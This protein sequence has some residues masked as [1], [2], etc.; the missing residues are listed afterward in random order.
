MGLYKYI[1][2]AWK[3]PKST[4]KEF[5]KQRLIGWRREPSILRIEKPTRLDRA[6]S[7]GYKAKQG[8]VLTRTKVLKGGR[9]RPLIKKGRRSKHRRRKKILSKSYQ[10]I[11]EERTAK[12]FPNLEV[13]GSYK[14]AK[15]GKYYFY[16]IILVDP[17]H[18]QIKADKN[19]NWITEPQHRRRVFRGKT[20]SA[21]KSRGLRKKGKGAEKLRPSLRS[22][23][24][25]GTN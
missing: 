3:K 8:F 17:K 1:R 13:L 7:L 21:R 16:E 24:R 5:Y 20:S 18:P 4:N 12:K 25:R 15:D 14:I 19:I 6:R 2:E 10:S 22:H 9:T 11:A 23:R